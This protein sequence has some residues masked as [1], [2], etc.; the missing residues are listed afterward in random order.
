MPGTPLNEQDECTI[1]TA[2]VL[3]AG[4]GT[5]MQPLTA[6]MPKPMIPVAGKP[7][8]DYMLDELGDGGV[9]R[10]V[11]NVHYLA[12]QIEAH[13]A[14]R[15]TPSIA[16]SDEREELLETGGGL[17]KARHLLGEKPF[18]STNTD[19]ILTGPSGAGVR[20]L[21]SHWRDTM[22]GLLLLVPLANTT[23]FDGKGDFHLCEDGTIE[24]AMGGP[25]DYAFTGVQILSPDLL[26]DMPSGPFSTRKLWEKASASNSLY[27]LVYPHHWLHVGTPEGVDVANQLLKTPSFRRER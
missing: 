12:E 7:L 17:K 8:L 4:L 16:F 6:T 10:I 13:L 14:G 19:A 22:Q 5:R 11:V 26:D 15:Q 20:M 9:S 21:K 3:A 1:S 27:G 18:I 25:A 24:H 2:M 23:G